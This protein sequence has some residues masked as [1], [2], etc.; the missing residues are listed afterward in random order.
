MPIP[1]FRC[2]LLLITLCLMTSFN[3]LFTH[4]PDEEPIRVMSYNIRYATDADGK[5][6][7]KFRKERVANQIQYYEVDLLGMQEVLYEQLAYLA[8]Q[9]PEYAWYGKGRDDGR[10]A[11]EFSPIFY[12]KDKFTLLDKGTFWLSETP[13]KPG[14]SW[15]AALPRIVT[16]VKLKTNADGQEFYY[17]NTHFDHQGEKARENSA[18]LIVQKIN[19]MAGGEP[20]VLTGD[21]NASPQAQPYQILTAAQSTLHD[22]YAISTLPHLGP[23]QSFSGFEVA[24]KMPGDRID[25]VFV[26]DKVEVRKHAILTDIREGAYASDH[27]PVLAEITF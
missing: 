8:D 6:A 5:H 18:R 11:G 20:V 15:D 1:M 19:S 27:L 9:L 24:P 2:C 25:Y 10:D 3:T 22:A 16:W 13:E 7:W 23:T 17:F 26:N 14:K 21:F 12:R 4:R